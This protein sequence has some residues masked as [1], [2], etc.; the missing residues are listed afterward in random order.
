MLLF[1]EN[2]CTTLSFHVTSPLGC[3]WLLSSW[4]IPLSSQFQLWNFLYGS[5]NCMKELLVFNINPLALLISTYSW[6]S[7]QRPPWG[8]K[9]VVIVERWPLWGGRG[10][11]WQF[12]LGVYN[13][14]IVPIFMPTVSHNGNPSTKMI[15]RAKIHKN[16]LNQIANV[17]K[18]ARLPTFVLSIVDNSCLMQPVLNGTQS[19]WLQQSSMHHSDR[20]NFMTIIMQSLKKTGHCQEVTLA[21]GDVL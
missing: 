18:W 7:P 9:K 11:I 21:V 8:Q 5:F 1:A 12:I 10:A 14:F 4:V 15:Y 19:K 3:K 13:M 17:T 20:S 6:T 16:N 2:H